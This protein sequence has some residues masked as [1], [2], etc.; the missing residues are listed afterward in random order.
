M[1]EFNNNIHWHNTEIDIKAEKHRILNE[2]DAIEKK[3]DKIND[4]FRAELEKGAES[5]EP[6][7]TRHAHQA[8]VQKQKLEIKEQHLEQLNTALAFC[9][10]ISHARELSNLLD[11]DTTD[12][13]EIMNDP[14]VDPAPVQQSLRDSIEQYELDKTTVA[15]VQNKLD[16]HILDIEQK[17]A[18]DIEPISDNTVTNF[19]PEEAED[20]DPD[21][22]IGDIDTDSELL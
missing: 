14:T 22:D 12:F 19:D 3:I 8:K 11:K 13:D 1:V 20:L 21:V 15:T 9:L 7:R 4:E 6:A 18:V 10:V 16:V 2:R 5:D 17:Q